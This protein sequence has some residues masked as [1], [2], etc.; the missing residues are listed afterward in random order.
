MNH[1]YRNIKIIMYYCIY[2]HTCKSLCCSSVCRNIENRRMMS[3]WYD[4]MMTW[5]QGGMMAGWQDDRVTRSF[6]DNW[7]YGIFNFWGFRLWNENSYRHISTRKQKAT[8]CKSKK[9]LSSHM[10]MLLAWLTERHI[11]NWQTQARART[12]ICLDTLLKSLCANKKYPVLNVKWHTSFRFLQIDTRIQLLSPGPKPQQPKGWIINH[13]SPLTKLYIT[14]KRTEKKK[15]N[16]MDTSNVCAKT[17]ILTRGR[18]KRKQ[19]NLIIWYARELN[20]Q[21][22]I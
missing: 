22:G 5:C 6:E 2:L 21:W 14:P 10:L 19:T 16:K 15:E 7:P 8:T 3:W 12:E 20:V 9:H 4:D 17:W 1:S 18:W 13:S 11:I